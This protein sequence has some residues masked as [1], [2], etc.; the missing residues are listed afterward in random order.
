MVSAT[1]EYLD[2]TGLAIIFANAKG[3]KSASLPYGRASCATVSA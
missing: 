1:F 3:I 2:L